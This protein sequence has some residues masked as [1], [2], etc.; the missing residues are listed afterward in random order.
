MCIQ[1]E[2]PHLILR[3][4]Q[5]SD[6]AP[7]YQL[8]SNSQ[9]MQYFPKLLDKAESDQLAFRIQSLIQ[10][11]EWGFWALELK[12]SQKFIGFTGLHYQPTLFDF[13]PCT[14]I[15]WRLDPQYWGKGYATEAALRCLEF[16]FN[17][18][19][20]D[21]VVAFTA[22]QNLRSQAVMERIG[23]TYKLDFHHP[24][25]DDQ[26]PLREHKLFGILKEKI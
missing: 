23:M 4:W 5:D 22:K 1:L 12:S 14:E 13:S 10:Q 6:L 21:E 15:G 19:N 11:N 2:T 26:S 25:L 8:N 20:L 3:Q 18:L 16:A 17:Q 9:V 24:E 7:F